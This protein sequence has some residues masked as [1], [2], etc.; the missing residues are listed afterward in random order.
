MDTQIHDL[1]ILYMEKSV[2][3]SDFT[4]PVDYARIYKEVYEKIEEELSDFD[5]IPP[6]V[7]NRQF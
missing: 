2:K 3:L 4:N 7:G 1:T 5:N 6:I